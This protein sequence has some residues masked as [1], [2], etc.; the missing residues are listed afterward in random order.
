MK[1]NLLIYKD[2]VNYTITLRRII[3]Q[4]YLDIF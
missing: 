1:Q 2:G 3:A 4:R